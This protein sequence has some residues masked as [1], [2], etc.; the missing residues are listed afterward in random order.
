MGERIWYTQPAALFSGGRWAR[1]L[2]RAGDSLAAQ[3]NAV[4][5]F[6]LVYAGAV[7]LVGGSSAVVYVPIAAA[8]LTYAVHAQQGARDAA[9]ERALRE[10][11]V[12][13]D[14]DHPNRLCTH[15]TRD[16]P[17]MNVLMSDYTRLPE[18]PA[19]C[20]VGSPGVS[21]RAEH[22]FRHNLYSDQDDVYGRT[23]ASRQFYTT[24]S[25]TIP[26]DQ[27]GFAMWL[28]GRGPTCKERGLPCARRLPRR[29]P[30][31]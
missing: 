7:L 11:H 13:R 4:V 31:A 29:H 25:T 3:L 23:T 9:A 14:R 30:V 22:H 6:A 27:H 12:E 19:A 1:L 2:P 26:N 5:R 8:A 17:F 28:Y 24:A 10:A 21:A 15:P 20:D 18:R 16:N